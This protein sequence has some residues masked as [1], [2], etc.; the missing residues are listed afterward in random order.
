MSRTAKRAR[1]QP[2]EWMYRGLFDQVPFNV[3]VIDRE[4][5]IVAANGHFGDYFGDW[6]GKKC[7]KVY[8]NLEEPCL[9]CNAQLT[10]QDGKT[11]VSD[12]T[13]RTAMARVTYVPEEF[14]REVEAPSGYYVPT[15]EELV[16]YAGRRL[17]CVV[18]SSCIEAS[19]CGVGSWNYLRVEGYVVEAGDEHAPCG[20]NAIEI[21]TI[22]GG[23][24]RTAISNLLL[25][26][27]PGARIE[28]R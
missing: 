18:G 6:R 24:E 27:Y 15:G 4:Y 5:N 12:E 16:D 2:D 11:R 17:L 28:F 1:N 10:F 26:R 3:A 14:G 13:G 7:Y 25:A 19:C 21:D 9:G 8:K 20:S 23:G 22:E